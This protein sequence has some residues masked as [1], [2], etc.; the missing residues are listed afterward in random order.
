[1]TITRLTVSQGFD[2]TFN[3]R[4]GK[5]ICFIPLQMVRVHIP[6][7]NGIYVTSVMIKLVKKIAFFTAFIIPALVIIGFY[8]GSFWNYLAIVF[9]FIIIPLADQIFGIDTTNVP[10]SQV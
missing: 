2:A 3:A 6:L 8:G 10:E 7:A 5:R 9:S 4:T 1:M